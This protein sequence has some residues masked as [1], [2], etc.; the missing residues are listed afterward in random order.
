[1]KEAVGIANTLTVLTK[2]SAQPWSL[3]AFNSIEN[4]PVYVKVKE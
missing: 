3:F 2:L 1:M 4:V